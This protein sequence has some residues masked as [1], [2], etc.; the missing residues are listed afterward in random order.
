MTSRRSRI[1]DSLRPLL[2]FASTFA[3][4]FF[5][6]TGA[7]AQISFN[8]VNEQSLPRLDKDGKPVQK[9]PQTLSP[10]GVS[11]QDCIDDQKIR[12]TL[13][14]SGFEARSIVQAWA[15]IGQD[16][17]PTLARNAATAV[18]WPLLDSAIPLSP[19]TDVDIPVRK[20]MSGAPP[21]KPLEPPENGEEAC[22]KVDLA[23]IGVHF[24][25]FAPGDP[26]TAQS[27]KS[28]TVTV[29][30]VGP[31]PPS[32]LRAL[33]GNTRITVN[34][35]NI[36]GGAGDAAATGGL[37]ELTGVKVYCDV[38]GGA[39]AT[40]AGTGTEPEP[41]C[42][43]E[44]VDAGFDFDADAAIDGGTVRVCEDAGTTTPVTPPAAECSSANFRKEDGS[45][46][47]P[48]KEFDAKYLCGSVT[49]NT[50]SQAV[51]ERIGNTPLTNGTR[52]AVAVASTD[53]F[54]NV[55]ELSDVVCEVPEITTDFW[56]DYRKA[57]GGA[58]GCAT[59]GS[60]VPIGS[61]TAMLVGAA[62]AVSAV[63]R[64]MTSRSDRQSDR[65]AR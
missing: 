59:T 53:R 3:A 35:T 62:L 39:P 29:D 41:E 8:V 40:E 1:R 38:T 7:L 46:I 65:N 42:R 31:D 56:E 55:G 17:K 19:V 43:D 44:P 26:T 45:P 24:L 61:M 18:C 16:C 14:M 64:R 58:G 36:S 15:S 10:E 5:V 54:G 13:Q 48:T 4:V 34:W 32:G 51:A 60:D 25:Y 63:R 50:G 2:L 22:G 21:F 52:Y 33:P 28:V 11:L 37:T 49:G 27:A 30:T 9:R 20:I 47:F 57:G 12:F 23:N 6:A